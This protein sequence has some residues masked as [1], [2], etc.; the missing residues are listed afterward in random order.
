MKQTG[1]FFTETSF[2]KNWKARN[3]VLKFKLQKFV[4]NTIMFKL[5][6]LQADCNLNLLIFQLASN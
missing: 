3:G 4:I 1:V 6:K 2:I 5:N